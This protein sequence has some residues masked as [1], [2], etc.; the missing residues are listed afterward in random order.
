MLN[1]IVVASK[2]NSVISDVQNGPWTTS[3][4]VLDIGIFKPQQYIANTCEKW[5]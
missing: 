4:M 2:G 1:E 5:S 3:W